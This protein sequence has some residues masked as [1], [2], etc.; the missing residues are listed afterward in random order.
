M[1]DVLGV[2]IAFGVTK[3]LE[4]VSFFLDGPLVLAGQVCGILAVLLGMLM[5]PSLKVCTLPLV[6]RMEG[7]K[8]RHVRVRA[9][10]RQTW[11]RLC[12][13]DRAGN[14]GRTAG[15]ALLCLFLVAMELICVF[16]GNASF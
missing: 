7:H 5:P 1:G 4:G 16:L 3:A 8:R 2:A 14:P 12:A 11:R 10:K 13:R 6:G 9:W 15:M